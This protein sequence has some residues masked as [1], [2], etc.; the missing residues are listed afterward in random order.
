MYAALGGRLLTTGPP[1]KPFLPQLHTNVLLIMPSSHFYPSLF[2][3]E[4][5]FLSAEMAGPLLTNRYSYS[6]FDV[7]W[8]QQARHDLQTVQSKD[9]MAKIIKHIY[10]H[11][12][13]QF[14]SFTFSPSDLVPL[15]SSFQNQLHM[16]AVIPYLHS[17]FSLRLEYSLQSQTWGC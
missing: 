2:I 11:L 12:R 4:I 15:G 1:R 6:V 7:R 5:S 3:T 9:N 8:T 10:H 16:F 14:L 13:G 17:P